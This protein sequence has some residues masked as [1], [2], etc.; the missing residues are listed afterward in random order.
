MAAPVIR[1]PSHR[2]INNHVNRIKNSIP[3]LVGNKVR[4]VWQI[5]GLV[6]YRRTTCAAN[7]HARNDA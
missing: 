5:V 7:F 1:T 4:L 2:I 3:L 6:S